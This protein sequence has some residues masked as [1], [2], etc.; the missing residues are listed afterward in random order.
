MSAA[1][2]IGQAQM[3]LCLDNQSPEWRDAAA[4][5]VV[6][7]LRTSGPATIDDV[8]QLAEQQGLRPSHQNA[9]GALTRSLHK[10]GVIRRTGEWRMASSQSSHGRMAAVWSAE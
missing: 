7:I 1:F 3:Q 10:R 8:R 6:S 4:D 5:I 9:W 2:D